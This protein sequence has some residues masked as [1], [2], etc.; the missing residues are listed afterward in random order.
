MNPLVKLGDALE[1]D[2]YLS[3]LQADIGAEGM[4]IRRIN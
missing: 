1:H 3:C 2:R 4:P